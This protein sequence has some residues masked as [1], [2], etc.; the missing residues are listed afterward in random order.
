MFTRIIPT[1]NKAA[2]ITLMG[3]L[4]Q[5]NVDT[6]YLLQNMLCLNSTHVSVSI[7]MIIVN[8][9]WREKEPTSPATHTEM[10]SKVLFA[11]WQPFVSVS[12][13]WQP[14]NVIQN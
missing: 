4:I 11:K 8:T 9:M 6:I 12:M 7:Y 13:C 3:I 14:N 1:Y 5:E 2:I 10:I